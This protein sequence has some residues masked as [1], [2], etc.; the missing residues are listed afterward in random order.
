[1][2]IIEK[3]MV[4]S[5]SPT[6]HA[7]PK[8]SKKRLIDVGLLHYEAS[9]AGLA[10]RYGRGETSHT[11]H[12]WWARR[13]HTAMRA[14]LFATLC[15]EVDNEATELL[16]RIGLTTSLSDDAIKAS[17]E[18]LAKQYS[19]APKVLD[20]FGGGGTIPFEALNLGA[21]TYAIDANELS[22]FI[23]K[24]NLSYSQAVEA[25]NIKELI[26]QS[27]K[28]VLDNLKQETDVLFPLRNSTDLLS[29]DRPVF[30][31]LWTYSTRCPECHYKYYVTKR[32]WLTKKKGKSIAFVVKDGDR[33]QSISFKTVP[34]DYEYL[35]SWAGRNGHTVCPK[36]GFKTDKITIRACEDEVVAL[37]R[38]GEKKG[39]EFIP[40]AEGA[41]PGID[42]IKNV[43]QIA[44]DYLNAELPS[45][46]LPVWSGIVNPA[47]Y[48]IKTHSEFLNPRQRAVLVLLIK[49]LKD[50]YS[51]LLESESESTAK[52]IICLLSSLID[53]IVDWNCRL[54]MWIPQNE[55]VGRGFCGPGISMLW[56]YAETDPV[57]SGPS[58]LWDKLNR[59][60]KGSAS[61]K[62][63]PHEGYVQHSYAQELPFEDNFFDSIVTDPPYY[64]NVYYSALAD[65]FFAWKRI[66]LQEVEP[67]LFQNASTGFQREL[68]ASKYRNGTSENAHENYCRELGLAISEAARVL[69]PDGCFAFL[70]SHSSINGWEAL[71]R[72][73]RPAK[74]IITSV[75]PL[76]IERKQRPR[77]M[78][79]QAINTCISFV[80]RKFMHSKRPRSIESI[81]Q[82]FDKICNSGFLSDLEGSGWNESDTAI[83]VYANG[84][85]MLANSSKIEGCNNDADA[86][87]RIEAIL[88][89]KIPSFKV[90]KRKS[91]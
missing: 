89:Q 82:E 88:K 28:S 39:K 52:Y 80:A 71:I 38:P 15:K 42:T 50:E 3:E 56:D 76:S 78:T 45:S 63:F 66:L 29:S 79:S 61:I 17:R 6:L 22:V 12:V 7:L 48:G 67:K 62:K 49:C 35:S 8:H 44:L 34:K 55:Q 43:E 74:L 72:A 14:L 77:A 30:A 21:E 16:S 53:Q 27:G 25:K 69:M 81:E 11:I 10:E 70:Y 75:Q 58:N 86:L 91:L 87:L 59:I 13:P 57:S 37:I 33:G 23:Q 18:Y 90:V 47:I 1:M 51:R 24:C 68:V 2:Q 19:N 36:C 84:V 83:A 4:L 31:Y 60:I 20:M 73:Y 64:D 85:A 40:V 9:I 5:P 65:F 46:E 54:S 32:P 41:I 26:S